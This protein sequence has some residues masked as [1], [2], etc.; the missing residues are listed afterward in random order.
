MVAQIDSNYR[1]HGYGRV[2]RRLSSYGLFEGRPATT[3]GQWLN[4][5]VFA[6]LRTLAGLPG[7]PA[8][9]RPVF[10][11]GL[12]RSGTTIL[13]VLLSLHR[14]VGFL[15]EPKAMWHVIDPR[16]D[17]N[18]NYGGRDVRY[19]LEAAH[20]TPEIA[21]RARRVFGR[22]LG[23]VG[24]KRVVDKYP[25]L[26]F[27]VDYV[28]GIFPDARFVFIYRNGVDACQSIVKWSERLGVQRGGELED[29]W[30]RNDS[31][32]HNM[33]RE[34]IA[35]DP[36]YAAVVA[37]GRENVDHA[38][39]AALEWVITMRE[40]L[41]QAERFPADVAKIRYEDLLA[42]PEKALRDLMSACGLAHDEA[43][44]DYARKS[45]YDNPAKPLPALMPAV[46]Q[47]FDETMTMLGY[48]N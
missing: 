5:L 40:G 33:W 17:V 31:K 3:K 36:R 7:D 12:G 32:W 4:P 24:A 47:L 46:Q 2:L 28:K 1:L 39:R 8:V 43:V 38:N 23:V 9:E 6:W 37:L 18:G 13:G 10:I 22:Y 34:L 35:P 25:E 42:E 45:L 29:W 19:R 30:G 15:N 16:Q 14:E 20:V 48:A 44:L 11:T 41:A 21:A 27:R 26:I